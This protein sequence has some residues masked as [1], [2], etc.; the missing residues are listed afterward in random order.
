MTPA[1]EEA[2]VVR[3]RRLSM[4]SWRRG[5]KEMDLILGRFADARLPA[6]SAPELAAFEALLDENDQ[7]LYR[8]VSGAAATPDAH[9]PIIAEIAGFHGIH[10]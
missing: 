6:L 3:L 8:W 1:D 9:R 10:R 5:M 4:R 7:D 2:P